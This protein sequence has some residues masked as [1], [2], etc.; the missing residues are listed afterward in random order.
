MAEVTLASALE[1]QKW[2][3][4]YFKEYVRESGFRGYM[5]RSA[6]SII[7]TK[8][9]LESEAGK[10][11]N[12]PLIT[13]L[14]GNGVTGSTTLDGNEEDLGNYNC[15]I[16]IDWRR[17]GVRVPKSTSYKTE[18]DLLNAARDMLKQ[19]E[20][21]K[22]RDDII[23]AMLSVVTTGSTTVDMVDSSAA[24][25]NA[26]SA[27]NSDRLLFGKLISNYSAT[28]ATAL[29]NID[30][31]DD[32]CTVASMSLAKRLAKQADPH[33]RPFKSSVGQE[34]F[35]AFHGSRTFRDLKAD[36]TMTQANREA[37]PRDVAAN[38]LFQDGDLIYDGILHREVP[39]IDDIASASGVLDAAG[40]ASADVRPVFVCGQQ[41][42]GVA[43]GQMPTPQ[44]DMTKDYKFRP[45]VA[46]EE[47][48]GVKKMA[49]NGKQ[50]GMLT[51]FFA[52]AADS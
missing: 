3:S 8:H 45:G 30:T 46:I 51:A 29:G 32:K 23:A 28:F 22:L 10:T 34:Y 36:S 37:R 26:Y 49:F 44:T 6:S 4:D 38:P 50:H 40:A 17:N 35:V 41:S 14:T 2:L 21:E 27:A 5:G 16:S 31:T 7:I 47:L 1:K 18:I 42:V 13:R 12:I 48:L 24:N 9:E 52:A 15:P 43:W 25:R 33:I 20:S 39:E 19:W 11:I